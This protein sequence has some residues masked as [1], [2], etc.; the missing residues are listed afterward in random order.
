MTSS[1]SEKPISVPPSKL[2]CLSINKPL[3][4]LFTKVLT[5]GWRQFRSISFSFIF[6]RLSAFKNAR[7]TW[8]HTEQQ[9]D[10]RWVFFFFLSPSTLVKS[11]LPSRSTPQQTIEESTILSVIFS[12]TQRTLL[13]IPTRSVIFLLPVRGVPR[14]SPTRGGN[15]AVYVFCI[16]QPSFP[17]SLYP[18]PVSISVCMALSTVFHSLY[19]PDN[20]PNSH[21]VLS[22][23]FLPYWP[24][25]LYICL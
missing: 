16:N 24:F 7:G 14:G 3:N 4:L 8:N 6:V 17:A 5:K 20:S 11:L 2:A 15:V 22:V 25:Q 13:S 21:C 23:L 9:K 18:V 19:S 10:T 12:S 1:R